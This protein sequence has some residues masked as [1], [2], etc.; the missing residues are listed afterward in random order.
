MAYLIK[1]AQITDPGSAYHRCTRDVRIGNGMITEIGEGLKAQNHETVWETH[2]AY[3]SPGWVDLRAQLCD[4]GYEHLEDLTSGSAAAIAGGYSHVGVLPN[5]DPR[6]ANKS[7]V[8]YLLDKADALP[9][10]FVPLATFS[11]PD[12]PHELTEMLDLRES[13]VTVF[14]QGDQAIQDA[15]FL[16]R[17]MQ[18]AYAF[19]GR[20]LLYPQ[21]AG[22]FEDGQMNEGITNI[23]LG[24]TG[25]PAMAEHIAIQRDLELCRYTGAQIHFSKVTTAKSLKLIDA[26]KQE[27]LPVTCDTGIAYLGF[28]E[29][30]LQDYSTNLKFNPP[31]RTPEDQQALVEGLQKGIVDALITDHQPVDWEAKACEFPLATPG[32]IG[33]QTAL[34][35]LNKALRP[36]ILIEKA[37]PALTA[38]PR[39]I[40]NLAP[41]HLETGYPAHLTAFDLTG[42]WNFNESTNLSRSTNTFWYGQALV[43]HVKGV[44]YEGNFVNPPN[45]GL[46]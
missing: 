12:R 45:S 43:G 4:P 26:A 11:K 17:A 8:T 41:V 16:K 35:Q 9:I 31:L 13:G 27:G 14:T 29:Q 36:E 19:G 6:I 40:L 46:A 1:N 30:H 21:M 28:H 25:S 33:L 10:A 39:K 44:F 37:I 24:L 5:T 3:L 38:N 15:G 2:G 7:Q 22:L 42:Q 32:A 20:L 18:Y 34:P 23:R